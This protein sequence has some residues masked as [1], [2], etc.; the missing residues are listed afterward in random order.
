MR[1][2][3][4]IPSSSRSVSKAA[5]RRTSAWAVLGLLLALA[6]GCASTEFSYTTAVSGGERLKFTFVKGRPAPAKAE[7]IQIIDA[8]LQPDPE[9]KKV[10][11]RFHIRDENAARSLRTIRVE[12]VT[13][14]TPVVLVEETAPTLVQQNWRGTSRPFGPDDPEVK[15]I[16]YIAETVRVFRFT[17]TTSD[18]RTIVVH[19]AT[20]VPAWMKGVIRSLFGQKY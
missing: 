13:D 19:Q 11:F 6:G 18:G 17:I 16:A 20:M 14:E 12:D 15:W 5:A 4:F 1:F 9:A 10:L 3:R 8:G 7:G 2:P